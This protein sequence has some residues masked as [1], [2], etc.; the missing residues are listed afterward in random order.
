MEHKFIQILTAWQGA[1]GDKKKKKRQTIERVAQGQAAH[2]NVLSLP[3]K[4]IFLLQRYDQT[5]PMSAFILDSKE[6]MIYP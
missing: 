6:T 2:G 3:S 4:D 5:L 1:V